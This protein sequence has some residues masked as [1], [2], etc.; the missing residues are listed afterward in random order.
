MEMISLYELDDDIVI[1]KGDILKTLPQALEENEVLSYSFVY[2]DTESL[3]A[4]RTHPEQ[5]ASAHGQ[6]RAVRDGRME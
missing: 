1:F 3:W 6:G 2:C 4:E 5:R